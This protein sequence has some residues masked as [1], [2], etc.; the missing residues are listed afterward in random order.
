MEAEKRELERQLRDMEA[1]V[2]RSKSESARLLKQQETLL[3]DADQLRATVTERDREVA[4]LQSERT[5]RDKEVAATASADHAQL[6]AATVANRQLETRVKELTEQ[7]EATAGSGGSL[8][9][10][11]KD[12]ESA[13]E[14]ARTE[15]AGLS[16]QLASATSALEV[17]TRRAEVAE[18]ELSSRSEQSQSM[19]QKVAD[20]EATRRAQ[21]MAITGMMS[22]LANLKGEHKALRDLVSSDFVPGTIE[23]MKSTQTR[24]A[25]K[26]STAVE[27][28]TKDLVAR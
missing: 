17:A 16:S 26:C 2:E 8:E 27:D 24:L 23:S 10:T 14:I 9:A 11:L 6:E 18:A 4:T 21:T 7:L 19:S 13:L 28:A 12:R 5:E 3:A 22:L 1:T 20:F 15:V 25:E